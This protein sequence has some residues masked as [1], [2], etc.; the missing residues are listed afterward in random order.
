MV[1]TPSPFFISSLATAPGP[2]VDIQK[3]KLAGSPSDLP[4]SAI[5]QLERLKRLLDTA[6]ITNDQFEALKL[7]SSRIVRE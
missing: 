4:A 7:G 3:V 2:V 1:E 5:D 6:V